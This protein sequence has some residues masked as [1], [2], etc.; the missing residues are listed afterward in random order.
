[1][2]LRI[3]GGVAA[4]AVLLVL[5]LGDDL[6]ATGSSALVVGVDVVDKDVET[7][8][9][10]TEPLRVLVVVARVAEVDGC[11]SEPRLGMVD[12]TLGPC[13]TDVLPEAERPLEE[14]ECAGDV[15]V[16]QIRRNRLRHRF[17][18]RR[19]ISVSSASSRFVQKPR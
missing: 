8:R 6:G 16:E 1:M 5:R 11:L 7:D 12:V 14:L 2:S 18:L 19:L 10:L 9:L 15:L 4:V 3:G 13:Q 17:L